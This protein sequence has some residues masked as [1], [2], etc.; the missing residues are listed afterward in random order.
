MSTPAWENSAVL[1]VSVATGI[2]MGQNQVDTIGGIKS[3]LWSLGGTSSAT[4]IHTRGM[5]FIP[6][7]VSYVILRM[8]S[9]VQ[10]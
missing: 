1:E 3:G 4:H 2:E 7:K 10:N 8:I 5:L 6:D 9:G